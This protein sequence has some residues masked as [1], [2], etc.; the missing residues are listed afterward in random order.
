MNEA[1]PN[2]KLFKAKTATGLLLRHK[3]LAFGKLAADRLAFDGQAFS[4]FLPKPQQPIFQP[5][6]EPHRA[7]LLIA[8]LERLPIQQQLFSHTEYAVFAA[9][10][11]QMPRLMDE[12]GRLR[13]IA[14]RKVGEGTGKPLDVDVFDT[15]YDHLFVWHKANQELVGAYRIGRT[16]DILKGFGK[17]G[18]YTNSLFKFKKSLFSNLNPA[19]E[20]GR[21]FVR[22]EYQRTPFA[23]FLL[24]KGIGQYLL[25]QPQY[26]ILFGPVSI[27]NE[28]KELSKQLMVEYLQENH[29]DAKLAR[30]VKARR[31][32]QNRPTRAWQRITPKPF[33]KNIEE[34]SC[35]ISGIEGS[36]QGFPVLLKQYLKLGA[37]VVSFNVDADF[38]DSLDSLIFVDLTKADSRM[39]EKLMG[40]NALQ[41]FFAAPTHKNAATLY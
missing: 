31:P 28:Y 2:E 3:F 25:R 23:L 1:N 32:F 29:F 18:L 30:L 27:S 40:E 11:W 7:D 15:Y 12:I 8:D 35:L 41:N 21:S 34:L 37:K 26:K 36:Q 19:L 4:P 17:K 20:M 38:C 5:I 6:A 9:K 13:E 22:P 16:D 33:F 10:A 14:F 39:L 24:W